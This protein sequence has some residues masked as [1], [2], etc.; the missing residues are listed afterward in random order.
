MI[1]PTNQYARERLEESGED[2]AIKRTHA[3]YFL[4]LAEEAEPKLWE[5]GDKAWFG[6]LEKEH[7]K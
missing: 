7:D 3:Q 6:R 2:Q 1:R 4:A 5:S